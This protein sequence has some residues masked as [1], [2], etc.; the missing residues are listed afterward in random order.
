MDNNQQLVLTQNDAMGCHKEK[1]NLLKNKTLGT[2]I[3]NSKYSKAVHI[4]DAIA[5]F[6]FDWLGL[7]LVQIWFVLG[8]T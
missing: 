7:G 6:C 8:K 2:M 1:K 4:E 5:L 3:I